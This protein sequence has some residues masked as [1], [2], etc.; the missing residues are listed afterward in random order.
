M[1]TMDFERITDALNA[2]CEALGC[3]PGTPIDITTLTQE[4]LQL[5]SDILGFIPSEPL[6]ESI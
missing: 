3:E 4:E 2:V 6:I 5:V 1:A